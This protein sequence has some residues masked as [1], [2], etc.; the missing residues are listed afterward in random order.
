MNYFFRMPSLD[1]ALSCLILMMD[2]E[3][4]AQK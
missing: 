1:W 4:A 3:N 2:G